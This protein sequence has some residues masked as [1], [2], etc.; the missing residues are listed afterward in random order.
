LETFGKKLREAV[1]SQGLQLT[2]V[3]AATGIGVEHL[4]ALARDDYSA[5][6]PDEIVT[7]ALQAF[8]RLVDV[9]PTEVI[10]DYRRQRQNWQAAAPAD[11]AGPRV[12]EAE[13][14]APVP[15]VARSTPKSGRV[16]GIAL[17]VL[18]TLTLAAVV[19]V[20][21]RAS[22][23]PES[24][25]PTPAPGDSTSMAMVVAGHPEPLDAPETPVLPVPDTDD[26]SPAPA[27]VV[28]PAPAPPA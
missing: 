15:A 24:V 27:P 1:E 5:L 22:A 25:M 20:W 12:R 2:D 19:L 17:L 14:A 11:V 21:F 16:G 10:A 6:P 4:Q 23:T 7:E 18:A 8:A 28:E 3:A 9:N 26:R 13:G